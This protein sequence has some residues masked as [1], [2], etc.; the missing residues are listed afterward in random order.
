MAG[1]KKM[2]QPYEMTLEEKYAYNRTTDHPGGG[3]M[4]TKQ[5]DKDAADIN[6]IV[7]TYG[8]SNQFA[9]VNPNSPMYQDNTTV[10]DLIEATNLVNAAREEFMNFPAE[11]RAL[12]NNDPIQFL[13]ML[14]QE[15]TRKALIERG[16]PIEPKLATINDLLEKVV[17]NT[18]PK[19]D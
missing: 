5:A 4:L 12:A 6:I 10:P 1:A 8:T 2:K 19:T 9:N 3:E 15:D 16:L 17:V 13:Q 14:H 7:R 18:T 11:V